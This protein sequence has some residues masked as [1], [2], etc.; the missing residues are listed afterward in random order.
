VEVKVTS[1]LKR[2]ACRSLGVGS[3]DPHPSS[4]FNDYL[5]P[6][7]SSVS[8][9]VKCSVLSVESENSIYPLTSNLSPLSFYF[10]LCPLNS[11]T[12][13]PF[14][15]LT[16]NTH[17]LTLNTYHFMTASNLQHSLSLV[18][19]PWSLVLV[20][21]SFILLLFPLSF[22]QQH[23]STILKLNTY[24]FM[25]A[26]NLQPFAFNLSPSTFSEATL[27]PPTSNLSP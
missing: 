16:L 13:A 12:A 10:S 2:S 17:N 26:S 27:Q 20:P 3:S 21:L 8:K 18:L 11:S 5:S 19:S 25:T 9:S 7:T 24:H 4:V 14:L 1:N 6:P 15:N 23:S 22:K